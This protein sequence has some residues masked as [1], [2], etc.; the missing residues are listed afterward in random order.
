MNRSI[1][2][3]ALLSLTILLAGAGCTTSDKGYRPLGEPPASRSN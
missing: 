2:S 1:W 3:A